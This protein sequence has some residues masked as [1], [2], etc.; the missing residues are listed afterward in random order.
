V[1]VSQTAFESYRGFLSHESEMDTDWMAALFAAAGCMAPSHASGGDGGGDSGGLS[2]EV[3][4]TADNEYLLTGYTYVL[5]NAVLRIDPGTVVAG[6]NGSA[7]NF[8]AL[9]VC[10]GG[11]I[12]AEG[13]RQQPII[14]TAEDDDLTDTED[15]LIT[16]RGL[17]GGLVLLGNAPINKAVNAAGD[18]ATPRYEVYEGLEDLQIQGTSSST[19]LA[20]PMRTTAP[21]SFVTSRSG[22]AARS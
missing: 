20:V 22:T 10:Q 15:L 12:F 1:A 17:W 7:P 3:H 11:K 19:A 6:R 4:W 5:N 13:T 8:G 16:D 9:Y 14:F 18:A 21:G 2:G